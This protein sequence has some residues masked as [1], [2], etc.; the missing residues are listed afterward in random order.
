MDNRSAEWFLQTMY[1]EGPWWEIIEVRAAVENK[2]E[3]LLKRPEVQAAITALAE[4]LLR[5]ETIQAE[6]ATEMVQAAMQTDQPRTEE[7]R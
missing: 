6:R 2:V 7:P 4:A 1:S 3:D 5:E